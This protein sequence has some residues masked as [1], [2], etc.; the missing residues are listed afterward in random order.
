MILLH[1]TLTRM[2]ATRSDLAITFNGDIP[3]VHGG[4]ISLY[5]GLVPQ[6]RC[7]EFYGG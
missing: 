7:G 1:E 4:L 5:R 6:T 3:L 2:D